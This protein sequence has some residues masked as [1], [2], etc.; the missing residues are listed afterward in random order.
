MK[1][2]LITMLTFIGDLFKENKG[3]V[4]QFTI[5]LVVTLAAALMAWNALFGAC[6]GTVVHTGLGKTLE[7]LGLSFART[8]RPS[9]LGIAIGTMAA[10]TI[11]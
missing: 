9:V 10:L 1:K 11:I 6:V 8:S 7:S 2:K 3:V 4:S 5:L